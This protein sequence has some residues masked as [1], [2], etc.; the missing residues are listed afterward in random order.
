MWSSGS[1]EEFYCADICDPSPCTSDETCSLQEPDDC[2][3]A[4]GPCPP[5]ATCSSAV[6]AAEG[7]ETEADGEAQVICC[8]CVCREWSGRRVWFFRISSPSL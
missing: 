5:V 6:V 7:E 8:F 3:T 1:A 2:D 4:A